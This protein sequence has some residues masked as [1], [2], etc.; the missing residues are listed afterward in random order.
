MS[1]LV[2]GP[3]W[4]DFAAR[5]L[6]ANCGIVLAMSNMST[7]QGAANAQVSDFMVGF[8]FLFIDSF[9]LLLRCRVFYLCYIAC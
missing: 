4:I 7:K 8:V 9:H 3:L 5:E 6:S 1:L 2:V